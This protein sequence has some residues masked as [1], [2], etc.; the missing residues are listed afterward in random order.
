[1]SGSKLLLGVLWLIAFGLG[2]FGMSQRLTS[3]H[4]LAAYGSYVPWG[5]WVALYVYFMGLSAGS[6]LFSSFVYVAGVK[7]L[8]RIGRMALL[9]AIVA[10]LAGLFT[11]WIDLGHPERFW[12]LFVSG[13]PTSMV[14]WMGWIYTSYLALL[15]VQFYLVLRGNRQAVRTLSIVGLFVAVA[16]SGGAGA[17]FGVVGAR[18]YWN[19]AL[20]P[21]LFMASALASGGALLTFQVAYFWPKGGEERQRATTLLGQL[22]LG[23]LVLYLLLEWAEISINLW[24]SLPAA[25]DAYRAFL[26]GPYWWVFWGVHLAAGMAVPIAILALKGRSPLWTGAAGLVAAVCFFAVR[27]NIVIPG[28]TV[29]EMAGLERAYVDD[30]LSFAY[31]PTQM[32]WMVLAFVVSFAVALF[33]AGYKVLPLLE[34]ESKVAPRTA[35]KPGSGL[36]TGLKEA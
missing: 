10:L 32:E 27:L 18:P 36:A 33:Y 4:E 15:V 11:V 29:P 30:R 24:A 8:E 20:F 16:L 26:F 28:Q 31:L 12:K 3:G 23:F 17:L 14:A 34:S 5:L 9:T 2:L 7:R 21:V 6:Y 1:M 25:A 35:G 19:S 13:Q 22:T